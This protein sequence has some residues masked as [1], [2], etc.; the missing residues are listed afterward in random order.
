M[1]KLFNLG[2]HIYDGGDNVKG[3]ATATHLR[4]TLREDMIIL[5]MRN[6]TKMVNKTIGDIVIQMRKQRLALNDL[7]EPEASQLSISSK[8]FWMHI[9]NK[10]DFL[11]K[12]LKD[13]D[14]EMR[15]EVIMLIKE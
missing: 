4:E 6:H 12:E 9:D 15:K 10:L 3:D 1:K 11:P 14:G 5:D 7:L 13:A 8:E 2:K